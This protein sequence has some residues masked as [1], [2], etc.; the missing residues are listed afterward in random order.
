MPSAVNQIST[1]I[2]L[3]QTAV[4]SDVTGIRDLEMEDNN[5]LSS[6]I[7]P[8]VCCSSPSGESTLHAVFIDAYCTSVVWAFFSP[9]RNKTSYFPS[10]PNT[11]DACTLDI[12]AIVNSDKLTLTL[13]D[14]PVELLEVVVSCIGS[15]PPSPATSTPG[16]ASN[17]PGANPEASDLATDPDVV[18][19]G[20]WRHQIKK[21]ET[22]YPLASTCRLFEQ[23]VDLPQH[24]F[25][26]LYP[27]PPPPLGTVGRSI[28]YNAIA[29]SDDPGLIEV[30][31]QPI[32]RVFR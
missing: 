4:L 25:I 3:V 27:P 2:L 23:L 11:T 14:L 9:D 1:E 12:N 26:N 16:W 19:S 28:G 32:C 21:V 22:L 7:N 15:E 18:H 6:F 8:P 5:T 30:H 29:N 20:N 13:T 17:F 10:A 24:L 31:S